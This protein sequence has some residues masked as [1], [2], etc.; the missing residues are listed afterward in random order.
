[1]ARRPH[2]AVGIGGI[3]GTF[4]IDPEIVGVY[5]KLSSSLLVRDQTLHYVR[6]DSCDIGV[7]IQ[8]DQDPPDPVMLNKAVLR[9]A[10]KVGFGDS[11][12][13]PANSSACIVKTSSKPEEIEFTDATN[14]KAVIHLRKEDTQ[15]LP[16]GDL[17]LIWDL[18]AS[19]AKNII[20]LPA[21]ITVQ[22]Q[23]G[24]NVIFSAQNP[25]NDLGIYAGYL[26]EAQ[27]RLVR[28]TKVLNSAQLQTD[29]ADWETEVIPAAAPGCAPDFAMWQALSKTVAKG[30]FR[31]EGDVVI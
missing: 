30:S 6:G 8:D 5:P 12:D 11:S 27:G 4:P 20:E 7:Q 24:S 3:L 14:G 22:L 26:F 13:S 29:F 16:L 1:M 17:T 10:V 23:K 19:V 28:V 25:W 15:E 9:F 2:H 21:D 31:V 18:E